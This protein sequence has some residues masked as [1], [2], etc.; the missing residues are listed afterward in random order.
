MGSWPA[1]FS[2]HQGV[3][4]YQCLAL[5]RKIHKKEKTMPAIIEENKING[6]N[7]DILKKTVSAIEQD[8]ALARCK[9]RARNKWL[10]GTQNRTTISDFYA[11]KQEQRHNNIFELNADEPALL[12]GDDEAPNPVEHLLNALASCVTT[13]IVAHAAVRGI[14]IEELESEL[15]GDLDMRGFFGLEDSVPKGFSDIR[16]K[17]KAKADAANLNRLKELAE[18]SPVLNT[19][20]KGARVQ[21][22]VE[23]KPRT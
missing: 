14:E 19:I 15:E 4:L 16:V 12:A 7:L 18:F 20:T 8:P 6:V 2:L 9:F 22:Q 10:R 1:L 11:A 5:S 23:A 17:F 21:V 3:F 13:S